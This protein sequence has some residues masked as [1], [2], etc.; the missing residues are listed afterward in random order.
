METTQ[1]KKCSRCNAVKDASCFSP[2]KLSRDGLKY[3]CKTCCSKYNTERNKSSDKYAAYMREYSRAHPARLSPARALWRERN[4][5]RIKRRV[6]S[7][8][9]KI[10][11]GI[12]LDEFN[13]MLKVQDGGCAICGSAPTPKDTHV[14]HDHETGVV[15]GIL[16]RSCN[17]GLGNFGDDTEIMSKAI[18]YLGG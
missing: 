12:T 4:K 1:T 9:L 17:L 8:N 16:C 13:E 6:K 15:R 10:K 2:H 3:W 18:K 7:N 5:D 14:D 11:Y